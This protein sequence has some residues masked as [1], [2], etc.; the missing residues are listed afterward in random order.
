MERQK[1]PSDL[2][3]LLAAL[4]AVQAEGSKSRRSAYNEETCIEFHCLLLGLIVGYGSALKQYSEAHD[5]EEQALQSKKIQGEEEAKAKKQAG[6]LVWQYGA[7][8]WAVTSS[9]MFVHHL[10][11]LDRTE[12][13]GGRWIFSG[14]SHLVDFACP[15][16]RDGTAQDVGDK[17]PSGGRSGGEGEGKS[18]GDEGERERGG[19]GRIGGQDLAA[20]LLIGLDEEDVEEQ[21]GLI[22]GLTTSLRGRPFTSFMFKHWTRTITSH[23]AALH[24]LRLEVA[25]NNCQNI[26]VKLIHVN[27]RDVRDPFPELSWHEIIRNLCNLSPQPASIADPWTH[28]TSFTKEQA[29]NAIDALQEFIDRNPHNLRLISA[30]GRTQKSNEPSAHTSDET[31]LEHQAVPQTDNETKPPTVAVGNVLWTGKP[32]CEAITVALLR[33]IDEAVGEGES[34][35]RYCLLVRMIHPSPGSAHLDSLCSSQPIVRRSQFPDYVVLS[36]GNSC[37]S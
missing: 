5:A 3:K 30:F 19:D 14:H 20:E 16:L 32:H 24:L 10:Q 17:V 6:S 34:E 27:D 2:S 12:F 8:L 31:K 9:R 22:L 23:F 13:S 36:V 28:M 33:F 21:Q 37:R 25:K 1:K 7:Y 29:E 4:E 26:G 15:E 18:N 35:L 11:V